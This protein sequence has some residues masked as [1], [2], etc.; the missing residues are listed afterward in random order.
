MYKITNYIVTNLN[1]F[2][3]FKGHAYK[4]IVKNCS[5]IN[6]FFYNSK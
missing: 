2:S 3:G 4:N 1:N 5:L 6:E